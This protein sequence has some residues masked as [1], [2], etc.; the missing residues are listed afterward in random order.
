MLTR[1]ETEEAAALIV[2]HW[3]A[4]GQ[5]KA[6]PER[7]RP[8]TRDDGY[9]IQAHLESLNGDALFGWKIAATS[10]VGQRHIGVDGPLA[11]RLFAGCVLQ[12][13][14]AP[15]LNGNH[16]TVAEPEFA[17]RMGRALPP[18]ERAY[19]RDEVLAA[20]ETLH[21]AIELPSSRFSDFAKVG[22]AQLIADNGCAHQFLLGPNLDDAWRSVNLS[23]H[24]VAARVDGK[25]EHAGSGGAVLG[26]PRTAL[27]WLVNEVSS[28]GLGLAA[29]QVVTTGTCTG[30]LP[31]EPGDHVTADF[32]DLGKIALTIAN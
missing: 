23:R 27:T 32:G 4:G 14:E 11:G 15:S 29:G 31:I 2:E 7:L 18:Q 28:L 10:D 9:A 26:D 16:M 25:I 13:D 17:F 6:L 30:P 5:M 21:L 19:D 1:E 20:V 22:A 24:P 8:T 3:Q 12:P